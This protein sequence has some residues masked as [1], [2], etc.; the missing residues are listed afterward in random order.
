M[1]RITCCEAPDAKRR[2][3]LLVVLDKQSSELAVDDGNDEQ[4]QD[5][6]DGD[7]NDAVCSHPA[8]IWSAHSRGNLKGHLATLGINSSGL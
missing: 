1:T 2:E 6:N 3:T 5:G 4:H 8:S 7:G